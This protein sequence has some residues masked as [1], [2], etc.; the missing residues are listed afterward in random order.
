MVS[1]KLRGPGKT[2]AY[3]QPEGVLGESM[4][5]YGTDLGEESPFGQYG[6]V[7]HS[8]SNNNQYNALSCFIEWQCW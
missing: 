6:I 8:L 3:P 7:A 5:K 4:T 1:T 2:H